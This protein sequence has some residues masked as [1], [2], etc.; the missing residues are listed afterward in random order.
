MT[1]QHAYDFVCANP[2]CN[3]NALN[4]TGR[5]WPVGVPYTKLGRLEQLG[6]VKSCWMKSETSGRMERIFFKTGKS[7]DYVRAGQVVV[8][9]KP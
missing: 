8:V 1:L 4:G 9:G 3:A 7:D 2:G 6:Y 5:K